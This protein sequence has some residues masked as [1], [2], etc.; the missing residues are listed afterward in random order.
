MLPRGH[1]PWRLSRRSD[2][3]LIRHRAQPLI[4]LTMIHSI[5]VA[6]GQIRPR[7]GDYSENLRRIGG[8]LAQVAELDIPPALVV[9]PETFVSGY[10]LQGGVSEVVVT[11]G[12]LFEDLVPFHPLEC[13]HKELMS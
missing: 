13:F 8:T 11:A 2:R 1:H 12:A 5:N 6:I 4:F 3:P 10:F 7:K 9:F